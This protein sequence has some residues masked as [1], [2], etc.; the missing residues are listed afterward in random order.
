MLEQPQNYSLDEFVDVITEVGILG[1]DQLAD[2]LEDVYVQEMAKRDHNP[3]EE[4][5]LDDEFKRFA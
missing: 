4:F 1:E 2:D 3:N 5:K